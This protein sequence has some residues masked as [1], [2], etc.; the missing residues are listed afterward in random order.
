[1][2]QQ[3]W[4]L[5]AAVGLVAAVIVWSVVAVSRERGRELRDYLAR[6]EA[7]LKRQ[8]LVRRQRQ[9]EDFEQRDIIRL[10]LRPGRETFTPVP[11]PQGRRY[12]ITLS[13]TYRYTKGAFFR[14]EYRAD[15]CY[16]ALVEN[17][18]RRYQHLLFDGRR[19][20]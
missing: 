18:D 8:E 2:S 17:F 14:S 5:P 9:K 1:M 16:W 10:H 13:G 15:A 11:L 12:T 20:D 7:A 3:W 4:V 6:R 19:A